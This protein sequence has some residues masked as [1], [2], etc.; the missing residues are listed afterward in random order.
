MCTTRQ[1]NAA[2]LASTLATRLCHD[3][4]GL[5]GTL[6]GTMDMGAADAEAR[7]LAAE[8]AAALI[9]RVRLI[10]IAWGGGGGPMEAPA[11]AELA[12]GLPGIERLQL[13]FSALQAPLAEV[14]AR[15]ALCLLLVA[16]PGM[17]RGGA[18]AIGDAARGGVR[19]TLA[20]AGTAW[21]TLLAACAAS[22]A[23]CWDAAASP[24][25]VAAPLLCLLAGSN[26]WRVM[27]E[28]ATA[29]AVPLRQQHSFE[30]RTKNILTGQADLTRKDDGV[31]PFVKR[32]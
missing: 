11:L 3:V 6:A 12:T 20:G 28:G 26:G 15:L 29:R 25:D 8:T 18:V 16:L 7:A 10:R 22:E 14:P 4:A 5:L 17:K 32:R 13:D 24:R 31:H 27:V 2:R 21:P 30:I 9:A 1:D 19:V 23:A